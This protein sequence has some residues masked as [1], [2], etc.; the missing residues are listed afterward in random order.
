MST[1]KVVFF[2]HFIVVHILL[3]DWIEEEVLCS[4]WWQKH[5]SCSIY[6]FLISLF[7][8]N[9]FY[10]YPWHLSDLFDCHTPDM[11]W[12]F[13]TRIL[14]GMKTHIMIA[15]SF[16]FCFSSKL[17]FYVI[18]FPFLIFP[19]LLFH[20]TVGFCFLCISSLVLAFVSWYVLH[21]FFSH[22]CHRKSGHINES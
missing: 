20:K 22:F 11:L 15:W 8:A 6:I 14:E 7:L 18:F 10:W 5:I 13:M 17:N 16:T 2:R 1:E 3:E 4:I 21:L 12:C 19:P 9:F